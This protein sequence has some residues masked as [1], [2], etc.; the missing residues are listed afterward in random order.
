MIWISYHILNKIVMFLVFE[1]R[2]KIARNPFWVGGWAIR[3]VA[4]HFAYSIR[5]YVYNGISP[6]RLGSSR[7]CSVHLIHHLLQSNLET[8]NHHVRKIEWI[9]RT[10]ITRTQTHTH[11]TIEYIDTKIECA[12]KCKFSD[13][14]LILNKTKK[15]YY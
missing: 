10:R 14:H 13:F 3:K 7:K 9:I 4:W 15:N 11:E 8:I 5:S 2:S 1:Q 6:I 12:M